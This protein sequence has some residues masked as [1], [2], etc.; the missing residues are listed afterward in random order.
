M[1]LY[2]FHKFT[3]GHAWTSDYGNPDNADDFALLTRY[4]PLHNIKQDANYPAML[5]VTNDHDDRVV[6]L[7]SLKYIATLQHMN[8]NSV[9]PLL[10]RIGVS[11]GHGAGKP[12]S[13]QLEDW[14]YAYTFIAK[15][16]GATWHEDR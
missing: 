15:T 4:S 5:I 7:H 6:P 9:N 10:A 3:I 12:T 16:T 13:K 2:K 8:Q 14:S 1:D 11:A